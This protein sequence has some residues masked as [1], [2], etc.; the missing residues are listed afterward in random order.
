[1][2]PQENGNRTDVRRVSFKDKNGFGVQFS[3]YYDQTLEFSA[4]NYTTDQ[5]A[6]FTHVHTMEYHDFN[7]V[8]IDKCQRGV[9][10]DMPGYSCLREPYIIHKGKK[11]SYCFL[12]EVVDEASD[13]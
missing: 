7:Y 9:G 4:H 5:L 1:M 11:L 10:G 6:K 12:M 3:A 2:R 8:T 13:S